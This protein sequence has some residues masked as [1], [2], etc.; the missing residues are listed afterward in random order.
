MPRHEWILCLHTFIF[1]HGSYHTSVTNVVDFV[2]TR[3]QS[4]N[5][6][7]FELNLALDSQSVL[8]NLHEDSRRSSRV[9][10]FVHREHLVDLARNLLIDWPRAAVDTFNKRNFHNVSRASAAVSI[11]INFIYRDACD[12]SLNFSKRAVEMIKLLRLLVKLPNLNRI[13]MN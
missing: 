4:R 7:A 9:Y 1:K 8:V 5:G 11:F 10:T 13:V 2:L 12:V 6:R 3:R